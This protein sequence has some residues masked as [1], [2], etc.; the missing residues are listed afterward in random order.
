MDKGIGRKHSQEKSDLMNML[1]IS[2]IMANG[3]I[4]TETKFVRSF[5]LSARFYNIIMGYTRMQDLPYI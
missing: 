4:N 3:L 2:V 1:Q 5:L